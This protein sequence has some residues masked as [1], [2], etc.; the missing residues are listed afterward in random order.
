MSARPWR[1]RRTAVAVSIVVATHNR[2]SLLPLALDSAL[3]QDHRDLEVLVLDDGSTDETRDVLTGY[4][5]RLPPERFR[6]ESHAN[7]GQAR[8]L[9]RGYELARGQLLGYLSDDDLLAPT[10]VSKLAD[11]LVKR[12]EA[13]AAY[14]AYRLID[15]EGTILDTWLPPEYTPA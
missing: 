8:T 12:P 2:A 7:M 13:S 6:F 10:L 14:P 11:A 9:N 3:G 1:R 4:A 5:H 15:A